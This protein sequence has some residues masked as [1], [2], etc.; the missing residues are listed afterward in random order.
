LFAFANK[1]TGGRR[2][3]KK[4]VPSHFNVLHFPRRSAEQRN[5]SSLPRGRTEYVPVK[6]GSKCSRGLAWVQWHQWVGWW[7]CLHPQWFDLTFLL[8]L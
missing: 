2:G 4:W 8:L 7:W 6:P 5:Q 3:E 1:E